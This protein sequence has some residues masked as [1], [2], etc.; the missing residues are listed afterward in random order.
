MCATQPDVVSPPD[1]PLTMCRFSSG[2][3]GK[4]SRSSSN[5]ARLGLGTDEPDEDEDLYE[6]LVPV[7]DVLVDGFDVPKV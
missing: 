3:V 5:A 7:S 4:P 1:A 6:A 2:S